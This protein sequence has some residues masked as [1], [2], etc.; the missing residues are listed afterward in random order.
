VV[1]L[2]VGRHAPKERRMG[3]AGTLAVFGAGSVEGKAKRLAAAGAIIAKDADAVAGAM[4]T[5]LTRS[6]ATAG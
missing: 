4:R 6:A 2:I 1:A 5:A 3:H